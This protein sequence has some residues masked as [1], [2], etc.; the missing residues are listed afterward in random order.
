MVNKVK[1]LVLIS[2]EKSQFGGKVGKKDE[3]AEDSEPPIGWIS[4]PLSP[5]QRS[6]REGKR[7]Q[8]ALGAY[9][10]WLLPVEK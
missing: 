3:R 8:L 4:S 2:Q 7:K 10:T 5:K 6:G 1:R 9:G